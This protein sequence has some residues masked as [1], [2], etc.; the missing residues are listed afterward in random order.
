MIRIV[1]RYEDFIEP[2]IGDRF[3]IHKP[4]NV[5]QRP[6]WGSS[7]DL[8]DNAV[9]RIT[10]LDKDQY[11]SGNMCWCATVEFSEFIG[12][13]H[14]LNRMN[15]NSYMFNYRWLEPISESCFDDI[16]DSINVD[17]FNI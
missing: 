8:Y 6:G 1:F 16:D 14:I 17:F 5:F 15:S 13:I 10:G 3:I 11:I 4:E 9:I 7:M 2:N 12:N